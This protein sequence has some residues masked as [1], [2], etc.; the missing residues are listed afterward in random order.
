MARRVDRLANGRDVAGNAG[1]SL[2]VHHHHR[3]DGMRLVGG[4]PRL[5]DAGIDAVTPVARHEIHLEPVLPRHDM[6]QIGE[7]PGLK[8]QHAVARRQGVEQR[9]LPSPGAGGGIDQY[10]SRRAQYPL[11]SGHCRQRQGGEFR[12]AVIDDRTVDGAQ[13]P[14]GQVGRAGNLQ[15][16]PAAASGHGVSSLG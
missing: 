11:Q 7:M 13:N 2:A 5:G 1:R 15:E 14:V 6:P 8:G 16:M 12:A 10:R 4:E 3:L 9:R